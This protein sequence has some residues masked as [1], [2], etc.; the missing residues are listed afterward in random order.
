[1]RLNSFSCSLSR[2]VGRSD[3]RWVWVS[4]K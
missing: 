1:M 2:I 3:R 4:G